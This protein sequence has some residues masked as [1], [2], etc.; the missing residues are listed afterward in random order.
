[1]QRPIHAY[2]EEDNESTIVVV[3]NG[4]SSQ[5]RHLD[6]HHR[7]SLGVVHELCLADDIHLRHVGTNEQKADLMTKPL[8]RAKLESAREIVGRFSLKSRALVSHGD[9]G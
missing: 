5:L 9:P 6:K 8:D 2:L 7:I 4:Y 1:M 3:E